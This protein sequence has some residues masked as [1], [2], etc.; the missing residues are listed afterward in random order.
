MR[1]QVALEILAV[2]AL[3]APF[4]A[5]WLFFRPPV[6]RESLV[7]IACDR[8]RRPAAR[9]G[10]VSRL[11][12]DHVPP[13]ATAADVRAAFGGCDWIAEANILQFVVQAGDGYPIWEKEAGTV[14]RLDP[15]APEG[16]SDWG[17]YVRFSGMG[18]SPDEV[19]R[20]FDP[21]AEPAP[22]M[23]LVEFA[24]RSGRTG[25]WEVFG[26]TGRHPPKYP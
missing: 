24:L 25:K 12:A 3:C 8:G 14:F 23:R 13:N 26:A 1:K 4:A 17:V 11:F 7:A 21:K 20:F 18:H 16:R 15:F 19:K 10:A 6:T 9:G 2:G 22:Q 5:W